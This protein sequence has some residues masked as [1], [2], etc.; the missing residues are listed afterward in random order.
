MG[1]GLLLRRIILPIMLPHAI[2][3]LSNLWLIATKDT[4]L[5]A[6]IGFMELTLATR[7]AGGATKA[8]FLFFCSAG[9]LYL[10]VTL[11]SNVCI[12]RIERHAYRGMPDVG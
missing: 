6:V 7:Q 4:A 10:M 8:Y 5:L 12:R 2:P 3:G 1:P 11:L 9:I